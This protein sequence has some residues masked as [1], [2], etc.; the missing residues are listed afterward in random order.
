MVV[1]N[2]FNIVSKSIKK[3]RSLRKGWYF[4]AIQNGLTEVYT[5]IALKRFVERNI[6]KHI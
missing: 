2:V 1:K 3:S 4:G 5:Q 6:D